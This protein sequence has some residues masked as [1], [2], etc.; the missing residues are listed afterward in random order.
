MNA[1][2]SAPLPL[3][4]L[5]TAA[6]LIVLIAGMKAASEILN[7]F[8]LS[9]LLA[10][11]ILPLPQWLM[12]KRVSKGVAIG[13]TLLLVI[14]GGLGVLSL[15]GSSIAGLIRALPTYAVRLTEMK[16]EIERIL[17]SKGI[18]ISTLLPPDVLSPPH[19]LNLAA[20]FLTGVAGGLSYA[21][22]LI[23]LAVLILVELAGARSTSE[24]DSGTGQAILAS[25]NDHLIEVRKYIS[26]TGWTGLITAAADY[27]L[28]LVVG[29]EFAI[30]WAVLAFFLSFIPN[31]GVLL[32][33]IP[34]ALLA[35]LTLGW[36]SGFIVIAG[37][38]IISLV[39]GSLLAP[40]LMARGLELSLLL[41]ISGLV[42][43]TWVLGP[44]GAI[45]A[46]PLTV[47][48]KRFI[49]EWVARSSWSW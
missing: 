46:V 27:L 22:V 6:C 19:L 49:M 3:R 32:A 37:Y 23:V 34:P 30:T 26:I 5:L 31:I 16:N 45:V 15:L 24:Q 35:F 21:L 10:L 14:F 20:T 18:E 43:W 36:G 8:L 42:F 47:V 38:L 7:L 44:P 28:M 13:L 12:R 9:T 17:G 2:P 11:A 41:I 39:V 29:V 4:F 25:F 48:A 33:L 1:E 40:Q